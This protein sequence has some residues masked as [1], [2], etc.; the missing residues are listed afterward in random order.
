MRAQAHRAPPLAGCHMRPGTRSPE[1]A[2]LRLDH[3][4]RPTERAAP[5]K[6]HW[7]RVSVPK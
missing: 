2:P 1:P 5:M 7:L 3:S 6:M 4:N